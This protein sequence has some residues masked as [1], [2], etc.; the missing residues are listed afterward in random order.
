MLVVICSDP[1]SIQGDVDVSSG[2]M[3]L[4]LVCLG[5]SVPC[6]I[7]VGLF[8][9]YGVLVFFGFSFL[10]VASSV[11]L[12]HGSC[13]S[14]GLGCCFWGLGLRWWL[15]CFLG[16]P[17]FWSSCS[18]VVCL[19]DALLRVLRRVSSEKRP[20]MVD[21][22]ASMYRAKEAIK[23]DKEDGLFGLL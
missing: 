17:P 8:G 7:L 20:A 22:Y 2:W 12:V 9:F 10:S 15:C 21:V 23:K 16:P 13:Y 19:T 3:L 14:L 1:F 6:I 18:T 11:S 4:G 5:F